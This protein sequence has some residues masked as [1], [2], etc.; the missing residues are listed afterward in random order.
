MLQNFQIMKK[1]KTAL[2]HIEAYEKIALNDNFTITPSLQY[3][4][5][6]SMS[7]EI[8]SQ[9]RFIYGIRIAFHF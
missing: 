2:R 6:N 4:S 7:Q 5:E 3:V 1:K 8:T 9:K